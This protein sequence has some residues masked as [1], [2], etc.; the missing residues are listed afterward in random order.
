M[1]TKIYSKGVTLIIDDAGEKKFIPTSQTR[2]WLI[3]DNVIIYDTYNAT[4][5]TFQ[6]SDVT[7]ENGDTFSSEDELTDYLCGFVGSFK[8]GGAG[9][10][11]SGLRGAYVYSG[12]IGATVINIPHGLGIVPVSVALTYMNS[13]S[14]LFQSTITFDDENIVITALTPII[15]NNTIYWQAFS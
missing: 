5:H 8:I 6:K 12:A 14:D 3:D 15:Q 10:A 11:L 7:N 4:N 13:D 1:A 9:G 2:F